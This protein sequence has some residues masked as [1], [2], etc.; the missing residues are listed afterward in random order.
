[1]RLVI[2]SHLRSR[3]IAFKDLPLT[4]ELRSNINAPSHLFGDKALLILVLFYISL[5]CSLGQSSNA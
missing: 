1:M 4:S 5:A 3:S 2:V